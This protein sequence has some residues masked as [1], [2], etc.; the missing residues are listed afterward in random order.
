MGYSPK[1]R[2]TFNNTVLA[3]VLLFLVAFPK[4]G[5]KVSGIPI[6]FGYILIGVV[7]GGAWLMNLGGQRYHHLPRN[8]VLTYLAT[9][10]FQVV[11]LTEML[12]LPSTIIGNSISFVVSFVFLSAAFLLVMTPQIKQMDGDAFLRYLRRCINFVAIYGIFLF[13]YLLATGKF[14]EIPYL[15]VNVD[16]L[17]TL[18]EKHIDRG[19]GIFKLISTYNNGNIYGVCLLMLLPLYDVAQKSLFWRVVVRVSLILTLSRT[20]WLGLIVYELIAV[21]YLRALTRSFLLYLAA[22]G[23]LVAFALLSI[24]SWMRLDVG[25][26]FD[27]SLG[28]R[29]DILRST[30]L[31]L[32]PGDVVHFPSEIVYLNVASALGLAGLGYF[33]IAVLTPIFLAVTG[34]NRAN[35]HLRACAT[36]MMMLLI[37][38]FSD[39]PVLLIPTMAFYWGLASLA[40]CGVRWP[41][42]QERSGAVLATA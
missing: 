12:M 4:A 1:A 8:S 20:V 39:G 36:G 6:T 14:V 5:F 13:F 15:T 38:G 3:F 21:F 22:A 10:P 32:V 18:G 19:G 24:V 11:M 27:S 28:G 25:F 26:L 23:A 31:E 30:R 41:G 16:D 17:G 37:C 2:A 7:A 40:V 33:L 42:D 34:R 9:V 29:V 35:R